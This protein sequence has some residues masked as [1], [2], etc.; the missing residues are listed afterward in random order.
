MAPRRS[1]TALFVLLLAHAM[2][3]GCRCHPLQSLDLRKKRAGWH[4]SQLW[5]LRQPQL[6]WLL[7]ENFPSGQMSSAG[8]ASLCFA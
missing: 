5:Y 6:Q 2:P 3:D 1:V 8:M 7:W 4:C